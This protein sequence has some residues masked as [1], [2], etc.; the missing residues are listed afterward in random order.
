M[1]E[2]LAFDD[3]NNKHVV[4]LSEINGMISNPFRDQDAAKINQHVMEENIIS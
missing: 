2:Y 3:I 1:S 4:K